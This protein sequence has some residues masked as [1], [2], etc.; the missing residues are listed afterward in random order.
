M[1]YLHIIIWSIFMIYSVITY[2]SLKAS[3]NS[4]YED[5]TEGWDLLVDSKKN[6]E[7]DH[8][9]TFSSVEEYTVS[10]FK[11]QLVVTGCA[12]IIFSLLVVTFDYLL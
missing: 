11:T 5:D 8:K 3:L 12:A 6:L 7:I 9:I 10:I 1:N 2:Y 4:K